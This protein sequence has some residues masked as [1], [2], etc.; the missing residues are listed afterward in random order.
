MP[1][2]DLSVL[3]PSRNEMWLSRTIDDVIAHAEMDTEVIAVLDGDWANPPL[4]QHPKVKVL[5]TPTP[6]GQRGAT[7]QAARLS[8]ARYVMKL[9]AHC[10]VDQGFDRKL[11]EAA[12]TLGENVTQIP[13]QYNFHVFDWVCDGCG[14]ATYQGPTPT[15]CEKCGGVPH[16][17]DVKWQPRK[18]RLTTAWRFDRELHFQYW[19][20]YERRTKDQGPIV[21]TMSCLGAAW[22]LSRARYWELG[23][24]DETHGSWGQMGTE[25]GCKSWLSGGRMV[26]NKNTW[27]AHMFRTQGGD[28]SF[29]Y[30]IH[31][32]EQEK[33]RRYSRDLWLNNK[34]PGQ[35]YPLAWMIKHFQP[36]PGWEDYDEPTTFDGVAPAAVPVINT[37]VPIEAAPSDDTP[38]QDEP[39]EA[40]SNVSPVSRPVANVAVDVLPR[41]PVDAPKP[42]RPGSK[43]IVYYS[44]NKP[45]PALLAYVQK[46]LH[47][48]ANGI[49]IVSVTLK[50]M[51]FGR[52]IVLPLERGHLAM[53]K[54]ILAGLEALDTEYAFLCEHDVLY[55]PEHFVFTPPQPDVYYYNTATW[56]VDVATGRA[57]TYE[58]KQTSGLCANREL[59]VA[60]YRKR[61]ARVEQD[62]FT[63]AMGFEPGSHNRPER[64]DDY[65]SAAW[66]SVRPNVDLRHTTNLTASRWSPTEFRSQRNC[67]GWTEADAVPGWGITKGRMSDI[68]KG[69]ASWQTS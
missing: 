48:A 16:H 68:I 26:T 54:Q 28:F 6:Y 53:F 35:K 39:N 55:A 19:G 1:A 27:F 12:Q 56:K 45:D 34:W 24:M 20:E 37:T 18:R 32:S 36:C 44:D 60:H 17:R 50:P 64:V 49:P 63:R 47:R 10:S 38:E 58:T 43:G 41:T 22:F 25:I 21:D 3:I 69:T 13:A 61:V 14:H 52:N 31:G 65:Q 15:K 57:V 59:L 7:N 67:K 51:D 29:P 4:T 42:S 66:T 62:G 8:E 30:V 46:Q 40:A 23:G 5:Y 11:I 9:D 2:R 33:A